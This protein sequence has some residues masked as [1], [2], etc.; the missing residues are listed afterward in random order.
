[1][2]MVINADKSGVDSTSSNGKRI[3]GVGRFT[4]KYK[5]DE[6]SQLLNVLSEEMVFVGPR[7]ALYN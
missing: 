1:M 4:K 7:P 2:S 3:I 5:L 6:F